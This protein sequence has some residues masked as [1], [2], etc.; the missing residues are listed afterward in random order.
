M[1]KKK[2]FPQSITVLVRRS[3]ANG[4]FYI[5]KKYTRN[6]RG[7]ALVSDEAAESFFKEKLPDKYKVRYSIS[8]AGEYLAYY[9]FSM[10]RMGIVNKKS[11]EF[12]AVC[13]LPREWENKYVTRKVLPWNSKDKLGME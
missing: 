5:T 2:A 3:K 1:I 6:V 4:F 9:D 12:D 10:G 7:Q 8:S 13:F 11:D